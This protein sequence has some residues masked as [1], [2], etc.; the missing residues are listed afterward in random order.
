MNNP[1]EIYNKE[2]LR[3]YIK[4][5]LGTY[6]IAR[7]VNGQIARYIKEGRTCQRI[8]YAVWYIFEIKKNDPSK[9]NGGI[10]YIDYYWGEA[11]EYVDRIKKNKEISRKMKT[12][13][14]WVLDTKE[15]VVSPKPITKPKGINLMDLP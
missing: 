3:N 10:A 9:S 4:A 11:Q 8:G 2:V 12:T 5:L 7:K 1:P 14:D 13:N 6:Y 15:Y